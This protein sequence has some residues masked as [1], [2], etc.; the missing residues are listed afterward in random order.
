MLPLAL[1]LGGCSSIHSD[2][3][4][5]LID[6]EGLKIQA[7]NTTATQFT[8]ETSSRATDLKVASSNLDLAL[9]QLEAAEQIHSVVF[10]ANQNLGSKTGIDAHAVAYLIATTYL[11]Q[12]AGLDQVV[13]EQFNQDVV[14]LTNQAQRI[15]DSWKSLANL[16]AQVQKYAKQTFFAS[17]DAEFLSALAEQVPGASQEF[18]EVFKDSQAVNAALDKALQVDMLSSGPLQ[19]VKPYTA[20]LMELLDRI[21]AAKQ[22]KSP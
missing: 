3:V 13:R 17:V 22:P 9:G 5:T 20:D 14:A 7:A 12:Q 10:S 16:H 1:V 8:K 4:R 6:K 21:K 18:Q 19:G 15:A 2:A 11:T